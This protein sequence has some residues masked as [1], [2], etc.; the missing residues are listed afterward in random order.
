M[1]YK[2]K[3]NFENGDF[4]LCLYLQLSMKYIVSEYVAE[5]ILFFMYKSLV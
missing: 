1:Y 5:R 2:C 3:H 4:Q